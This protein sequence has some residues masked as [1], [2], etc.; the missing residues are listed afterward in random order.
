MNDTYLLKALE[1]VPDKR[2]LILLASKRAKQLARGDR[3]LIRHNELNHVDVALLEIAEGLLFYEL[4]KKA[5]PADFL[6]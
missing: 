4:P 1:K 2:A 6:D 3:P 5:D